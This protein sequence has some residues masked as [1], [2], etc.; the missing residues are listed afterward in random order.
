MITTKSGQAAAGRDGVGVE[1][2]SSLTLDSFI[3]RTNF[4]TAYGHGTGGRKPANA[5][6][7]FEYGGS[8]WGARLDGTPVF[9]FDGEERPYSARGANNFDNFYRTGLT[10]T[11]TVAL[12]GGNQ[13]Q[14][15]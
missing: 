2:N 6:E 3:D 1:F 7:G 14:T 9:Q 8:A 5:Q 10:S 11:N 12:T 15:F 4:Q 13:N